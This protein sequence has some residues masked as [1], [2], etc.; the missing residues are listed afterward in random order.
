MICLSI[1]ISPCF[2]NDCGMKYEQFFAFGPLISI[3]CFVAAFHFVV[4]NRLERDEKTTTDGLSP[5]IKCLSDGMHMAFSWDN[6][7]CVVMRMLNTSVVDTCR[8]IGW[9]SRY[10][11]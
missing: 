2:L 7:F 9:I 8:Q 11:E 5:F 3:L 4:S 10:D 6:G 1:A